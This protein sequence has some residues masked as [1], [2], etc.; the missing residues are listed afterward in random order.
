MN[1]ELLRSSSRLAVE[2]NKV[3]LAVAS[4]GNEENVVFGE[5]ENT[6]VSLKEENN[7]SKYLI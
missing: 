2:E 1:E 6:A 4:K 5:A 7:L 3:K